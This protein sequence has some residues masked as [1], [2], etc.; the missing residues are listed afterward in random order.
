MKQ[1]SFYKIPMR[2]LV[3]LDDASNA[4][5]YSLLAE[6]ASR[7]TDGYVKVLDFGLAEHIPLFTSR[8]HRD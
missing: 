6:G 5:I 4:L 2:D 1:Q 3:A 8:M 7:G